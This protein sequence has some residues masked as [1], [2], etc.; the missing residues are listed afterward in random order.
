MSIICPL[1][2]GSKGNSIFVGTKK[3]GIL[4]DAGRSCKQI[5]RALFEN[6]ID[7]NA[8]K[9]IFLTHEHSDQVSGVRVFASKYNLKVFASK[10]TM[11]A[12]EQ[13]GL[14]NGKFP[15]DIL[16]D[17]GTDVSGMFIN[18]FKTPHDSADSVGY[19]IKTSD[20][21]KAV[22]ATDIGFVSDTVK[23]AIIGAD[24]VVIE[25]NHNVKM[26]ENGPYPYYLKRRILSDKGHLS[27]ECCAEVLP[28][29]IENGSTKFILAHLSQ[30]NN[31]PDL[32]FET[33]IC[34]LKSHNMKENVDF[35]MF[36]AP[37][38]N[39]GALTINV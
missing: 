39:L 24:A 30:E 31:T 16:N 38:E 11:E 32:A 28:Y 37:A 12:I 25:S 6:E 26:L 33:A 36:V 15:C 3:E 1:F 14:F 10:G 29:F 21:K 2:S 22:I 23:N 27:N 7:I 35:K 18:F 5:E 13:K 4:V 19:I 17:A 20:G 8:I 9:A 34:S